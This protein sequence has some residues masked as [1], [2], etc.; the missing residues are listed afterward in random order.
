MVPEIKEFYEFETNTGIK[1]DELSVSSQS[2][3][4]W[5]CDE[6]G[7]K[8]NTSVCSRIVFDNGKYNVRECPS[9]T[10]KVR[11]ISYG[12]EYPDL[13]ER[14]VDELNGCSL[15]D[16]FAG[17]DAS[18]KY[19][20]HCDI[21]DENFTA[22]VLA[23]IRARNTASKGCSYCSGKKVLVTLLSN[24]NILPLKAKSKK[25]HSPTFFGEWI[26]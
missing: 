2:L 8:W 20:W 21:C 3:V 22:D 26:F 12:E 6:C 15:L 7:Y 1:P 11:I 19:F 17:K 18:K 16:I 25:I 24:E 14:F 23:L 5:K 9:C 10:G 13:V 4:N